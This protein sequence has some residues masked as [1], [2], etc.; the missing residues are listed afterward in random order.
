M[1]AVAS[2][3]WLAFV[4]GL[5]LSVEGQAVHAAPDDVEPSGVEHSDVRYEETRNLIALVTDAEALI[6]SGG[7]EA[8]CASFREDGSKWLRDEAYVFVLDTEGKT[9]CHPV[10]PDYEGKS[11][12]ELRDPHGKPIQR[13]FLRELEGGREDGW[14]HYHWPR[15]G[16]RTF[17]WKTTYLRRAVE[18]EGREVIV[19]SGLYQMRM[20][21]FFVVEQVN[22]AADLLESRGEAGFDEIRDRSSGFRFLDAYIFVIDLDGNHVVNVGFP[23]LEGTNTIDMVDATGKNIGRAMLERVANDGE[24]W[25]DYMWPRPGDERAAK[26]SSYVRGV[27][28]DGRQLVVGAGIYVP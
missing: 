28:V 13:N 5:G 18:P 1:A 10:R 19:G 22:D 21:P 8:A 4:L 17:Y 12:L 9:L 26:K 20:E 6:E 3:G 15:P 2:H 14:V 11:Q 23:E 7:A 25:V 16:Q 27:E 24:G